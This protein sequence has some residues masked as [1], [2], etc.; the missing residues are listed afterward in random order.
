MN[1]TDGSGEAAHNALTTLTAFVV[2][3]LC[4]LTVTVV[5]A[6]TLRPIVYT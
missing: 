3:T 6:V 4:L 2:Y 1:V 5:Y